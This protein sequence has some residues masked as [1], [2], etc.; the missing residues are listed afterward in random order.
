MQLTIPYVEKQVFMTP[1]S[2]RIT[3]NVVKTKKK[4]RPQRQALSSESTLRL[5]QREFLGNVVKAGKQYII[6]PG[7]SGL[8]KLDAMGR[9]FELYRV[10]KMKFNYLPAVGT[11]QAGMVHLAF[12]YDSADS[13]L[14]QI[15]ISAIQPGTRSPVWLS[16]ELVADP[17]RMSRANWMFTTA[18]GG[19]HPD[20]GA[21]GQLMVF[22]TAAI[23]NVG[24]LWIDYIVEFSNPVLPNASE[25]LPVIAAWALHT[26]PYRFTCNKTTGI[27]FP[28]LA[29]QFGSTAR[30]GSGEWRFVPGTCNS[31][32]P[33][34]STMDMN[35][36]SF[37]H[38]SPGYRVRVVVDI[39]S[40]T[41][42]DH[43]LVDGIDVRPGNMLQGSVFIWTGEVI[44]NS[45]YQFIGEGISSGSGDF[46][47]IDFALGALPAESISAT[48]SVSCYAIR[49]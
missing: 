23:D 4:N 18:K 13:D 21:V 19:T 7:V 1:V 6:R 22:N 24:E 3:T 29:G 32:G 47:S 28:L 45:S 17:V 39:M 20:T 46:G 44:N 9:M 12:D 11:T 33:T 15:G 49:G 34:K 30:D 25:P 5:N 38:L 41:L 16:S 40:D 35:F 37:T 10:L 48:V 26:T 8:G 36:G 14:T 31:T 43:F 2:S 27:S 42:Q